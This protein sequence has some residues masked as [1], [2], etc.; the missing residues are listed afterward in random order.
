M[1]HEVAAGG[2]AFAVAVRPAQS[3]PDCPILEAIQDILLDFSGV[4]EEPKALHPSRAYD[5]RIP[6][7]DE[8]G[9]I[10]ARP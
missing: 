1:G 8:S 10:N 3:Q 6:I 7:K 9:P 4:M 5:H 2:E